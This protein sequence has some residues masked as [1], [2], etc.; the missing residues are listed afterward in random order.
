MACV[1]SKLEIHDNLQRR[2]QYIAAFCFVE[3][4]LLEAILELLS[5]FLAAFKPL[6]VQVVPYDHHRSDYAFSEVLLAD[7]CTICTFTRS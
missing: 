3:P 6:Q 1:D 7:A 2:I 5:G 4:G